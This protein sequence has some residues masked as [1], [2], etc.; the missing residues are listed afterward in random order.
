MLDSMFL[1]IRK[2][3]DKVGKSSMGRFGALLAIDAVFPAL[4]LVVLIAIFTV[5][6]LLTKSNIETGKFQKVFR[7]AII[8]AR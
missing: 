8:C 3:L 6:S 7:L 5:T 1:K 2:L 4:L